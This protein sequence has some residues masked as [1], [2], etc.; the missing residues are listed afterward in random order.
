MSQRPAR[1]RPAPMRRRRF[2]R[3]VPEEHASRLEEELKQ[4]LADV[5]AAR[6]EMKRKGSIPWERVKAELGLK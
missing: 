3:K 6:R 2:A 4:D 1:G 5:R